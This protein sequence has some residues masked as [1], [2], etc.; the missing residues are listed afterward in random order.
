MKPEFQAVVMAAGTGSRFT[1]LTSQRAKCLLPLGN[2]PMVWYPLNLLHRIGFQEAIVIVTETNRTEIAS[3]PKKF[4]GLG[5]LRLDIVTLPTKEDLGTADALRLAAPRLTSPRVMVLSCDLVTDL[6]IHNLTD[7]HRVHGAAVTALFARTTLDP[8]SIPVPGPKSKPKRERDLV[9]VD[10]NT[11]QLCYMAS[12]ADLDETA[13]LRRSLLMEHPHINIHTN[14]MDAHFYIMDKWVIDFVASNESITSIKGELIPRLVKKQFSKLTKRGET[15]DEDDGG[16]GGPE[17]EN[18]EGGSDI[19]SFIPKD[20][21]TDLAQRLS[22]WNDHT[23]DLKEAY[24]GRPLRC[25]AFIQETGSCY[26]ANTLHSFCELNRQMARLWPA[27][28]PN[29]EPVNFHPT[30]NIRPRAQVGSECLVGEG[31]T[32]SDKTTL[33]N[34]I[35][36][37][38]CLVEEKVR[39]TNCIMMDNVTVKEGCNLIGSIVCDGATVPEGCEIKD[40]IVAKGYTFATGAKY[41]NEVLA[42][43]R[44]RMM[45]I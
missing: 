19:Q 42:E 20:P 7:V 14:L 2:L 21:M 13:T 24:H 8:K 37:A 1:E 26:R 29:R 10:V 27:V 17:G 41:S 18:R 3:I 11:N 25:Y 12:A 45:E 15:E 44:D 40:C 38:G 43:D 28:A 6:P 30:A 22:F 32:V 39:L 33:K 5:N 9:G 23:G 35:L 34:S 36:G 16:G 4:G 31:T